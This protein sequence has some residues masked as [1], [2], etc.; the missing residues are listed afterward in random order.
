MLGAGIHTGTTIR[1]LL[2]NLNTGPTYGPNHSTGGDTHTRQEC[3]PPFPTSVHSGEISN[4]PEAKL[5]KCPS[6]G[7][8]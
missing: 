5:P 3:V 2:F 7:Q 1:A 6:T 4:R 8:Q